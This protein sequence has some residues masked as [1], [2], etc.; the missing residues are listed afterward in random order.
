MAVFAV[1]VA[2]RWQLAP[3]VPAHSL[4]AGFLEKA[5]LE[6]LYFANDKNIFLKK[7]SSILIFGKI[8]VRGEER[9]CPAI[10]FGLLCECEKSTEGNCLV[11]TILLFGKKM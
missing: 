3:S 8:E 9:T 5:L 6:S 7:T 10:G 11:K 2:S 1:V 4:P